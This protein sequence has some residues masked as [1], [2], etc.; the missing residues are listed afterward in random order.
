MSESEA[1]CLDASLVVKLYLPE[2]GSEAAEQIL[3][4]ALER[5]CQLLAP[6]FMPAEVL[7]VLRR[8]VVR[9][10]VTQDEGK[11]A[12]DSLFS[13]PF[14]FVEGHEMYERAWRIAEDLRLATLY[15]AAYL[16]VADLR[17]AVFWTAD[18]EFFAK[19]T[20]LTYV[21]LLGR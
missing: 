5:G 17:G 2:P 6:A 16:A 1:I 19:A 14:D 12:L 7:S 9:G 21:R 15:D 10:Q 20:A 3:E 18:E 13:L 11:Q 8:Q 4:E